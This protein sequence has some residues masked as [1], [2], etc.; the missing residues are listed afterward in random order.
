MGTISG[1]SLT[2]RGSPSTRCVNLANASKLSFVLAFVTTRSAAL[3]FFRSSIAC[4]R[5]R[6]SCTRP[7]AYQTSR[8]RMAANSRIADRYAPVAPRT[9]SARSLAENPSVPDR[10]EFRYAALGLLL[11]ESHRIRAAGWDFPAGVAGARNLG[12]GR[13]APSGTLLGR[14]VNDRGGGPSHLLQ[15]VRIRIDLRRGRLL[16]RAPG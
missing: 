13:L 3:R 11:Q 10:N 9:M 7:C 16:R 4:K 15:R 1:G 6:P 5:G 14:E 12:A 8:F 2:I